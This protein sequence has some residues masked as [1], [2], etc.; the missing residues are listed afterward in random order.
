MVSFDASKV[1]I[2]GQGIRLSEAL[3]ALQSQSG[4]PISDMRELYGQDAT[5]PALDLDIE[6]RPFFEALDQITRQAGLSPVFY[7]GDGTIG[8]DRVQRVQNCGHAT[9]GGG[10]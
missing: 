8:L 3:R 9:Q 2:K 5:N 4:N 1:T 7:T 6:D 10:P